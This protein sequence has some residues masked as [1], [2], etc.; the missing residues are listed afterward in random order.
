MDR[1]LVRGLRARGVDA[2]T[3]AQAGRNRLPDD[4]QLT[5]AASQGRVLYTCNVGD[6]TRIHS[7]RLREGLHHAGIIVLTDQ[8]TPVGVQIRALMRLAQTFAPE[9]MRDRVEFL[10]NWQE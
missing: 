4:E 5:L 10:S 1:A 2:V 9:H 3:T 8:L 7:R 6:F